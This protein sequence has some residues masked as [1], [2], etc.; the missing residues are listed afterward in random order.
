[1]SLPL[2]FRSTNHESLTIAK[3]KNYA[4]IKK[5]YLMKSTHCGCKI[6]L[7]LRQPKRIIPQFFTV[8]TKEKNE[9]FGSSLLLANSPMSPK[10]VNGSFAAIFDSDEFL[11][12]S[13][14]GI[15]IAVRV[16]LLVLAQ[17]STVRSEFITH[18][19]Y[20]FCMK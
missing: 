6:V 5:N 7:L 15:R 1:M 9:A 17:T 18:T 4:M 16:S 12:K 10:I 2:V 3:K 8:D 14:A 20:F 11:E 13:Y 19:F